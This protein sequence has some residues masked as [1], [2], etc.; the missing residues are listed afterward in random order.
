M[1][2]NQLRK[3]KDIINKKEL[4]F[5]DYI[6]QARKVTAESEFDIVR[7]KD[8]KEKLRSEIMIIENSKKAEVEAIRSR[9]ERDLSLEAEKF[10]RAQ[11]Q[12]EDT[13][14]IERAKMKDIV[15]SKN[16]EVDQALARLNK[17][18]TFYDDNV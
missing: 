3:M 4:E 12:A 8:D 11:L 15:D 10:K 7:L 1:F 2:E 6:S 18:K 17:Q 14:Q 16:A 9:L 5:E 13:L